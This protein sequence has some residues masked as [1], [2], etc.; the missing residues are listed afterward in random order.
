MATMGD[1]ARQA[2]VSVSTVSHVVNGTR[3]IPDETR[4]RVLASIRDLGYHHTPARRSLSAGA[5]PTVGLV[6][7]GLSNPHW[8]ALV[9][10][11]DQAIARAGLDLFVVD[12]RDDPQVE[13]RVVANLLAH[14]IAGLIVAPSSGWPSTASTLLREHPRPYVIIDRAS[15]LPIDQVTVNNTEASA[16]AVGHLLDRGRAR[17]GMVSGN[18]AVA[19]S[20]ERLRGYVNAHLQRGLE[21]DPRLIAGGMSSFEGARVAVASLLALPDPPTALFTANNSMTVGAMGALRAA[22]MSVPKDLALIGFDDHAW[23]DSFTPRLTTI[24][25]PNQLIGA[26]AVKLLLDRLR[27]P[28]GPVQR[29]RLDTEFMHRESCGCSP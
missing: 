21:I 17:V 20:Q 2:G 24:A 27:S 26:T 3:H 11:I 14:H 28:S 4:L 13:A 12:S 5:R 16:R 9:S 18:R 1:V 8:S 29:I 23:A 25:Q 7:S 22:G 10:A 6:M 19:T 15:E